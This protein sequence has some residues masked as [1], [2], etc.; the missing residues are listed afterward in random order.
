MSTLL[1]LKA[2]R[3]FKSHNLFGNSYQ[4]LMAFIRNS[5]SFLA[6]IFTVAVPY[7][8]SH[9]NRTTH[10]FA[11]S[12]TRR[13]TAHSL[14]SPCLNWQILHVARTNWQCQRTCRLTACSLPSPIVLFAK[15]LLTNRR[16][17]NHK[18]VVRKYHFHLLLNKSLG[19]SLP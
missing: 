8:D 7:R 1:N 19:A 14:P 15:H 11:Y 2:R 5:F 17:Y 10:R 9:Y 18:P 6:V 12:Q 16:N 3:L 13:L 4:S